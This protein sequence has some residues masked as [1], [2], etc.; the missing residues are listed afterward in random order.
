MFVAAIATGCLAVLGSLGWRR[1]VRGRAVEAS[2]QGFSYLLGGDPGAAIAVLTRV[3]ATGNLEAYF[4]L[5]ALFRRQGELDRAI[6]LHRNI[7]KAPALLGGQRARALTELGRDFRKAQLGREAIEVL[8]Q[9]CA[10]PGSPAD[11]RAAAEELRDA[12]LSAGEAR[13][14]AEV[15]DQ[16]G[17]GD[18]DPLAAHLWAEAALLALATKDLELAGEAAT[19]A[20]GADSTSV[21]AR[22]AEL[23]VRGPRMELAQARGAALDLAEEHPWAGS[24]VLGWLCELELAG[25]STLALAAAL[26][27]RGQQRPLSAHGSLL[28]ADLARRHGEPHVAA[29]ELQSLLERAPEFLPARQLLSEILIET[30]QLGEMPAQVRALLSALEG[31]AL[32]RCR[33]CQAP[34]R[35]AGW[36]CAACG[37][38]D[39]RQ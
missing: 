8:R 10:E 14:A 30:G 6:Q 37:A 22:F 26:E 15:Q 24:M 16:L 20:R 9:A 18:V 7:L 36:R 35:E 2:L 13:A 1:R 39:F 33:H 23:A 34:L 25:G 28:K 29:V 11:T 5:G 17:G 19:R 3:A 4:A 12:Y 27:L 38:F 31:V 32:P 21:H